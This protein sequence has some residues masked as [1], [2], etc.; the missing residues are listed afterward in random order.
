MNTSSCPACGRPLAPDAPFGL[1][2][3]CLLR[4]GV[5]STAPAAAGASPRFVAPSPDE[6]APLFPQLEI[7]ALIGQGGMGAVYRARQA[8]L[9]RTV[10]L[11]ILPPPTGRDPGFTERFARE[12]RAL[13]RLSHPNIVAVHDVG[14]T[15]G[16]HYLLME[17]VD[18]VTLRHLLTAGKIAPREA[19]AIVPQICDALQYAHDKGI[20][21]RDIKPENILLDKTGA[22]KIADFGLAKIVGL[23]APDF[24]I[25]GARDVMGTL[26]YMA[27]EQVEH[28]LEVDHRADIYSVGVVFYQMLTGELPLGR[29]APPSRKV[30]IDVRLDEVVLRAL[31]KEPALRYQQAS[32]FKTAVE[33]V[34]ASPAAATGATAVDVSR[35]WE[36][37][38]AAQLWGWPLVHIVWGPDPATGKSPPAKGIIAIGGLAI[39]GV[40]IGGT[41]MGGLTLGGLSLGVFAFG[42]TAI[43]AFAIGGLAL[44]LLVGLGGLVFAPV[45]LGLTAVGYLALGNVA[46]G[47][48]AIG[49]NIVDPAARDFFVKWADAIV[50]P[51]ITV[52]FATAAITAIV[53]AV[54]AWRLLRSPLR[55]A[56]GRMRP[57]LWISAAIACIAGD[58][59]LLDFHAAWR[60][61]RLRSN[62]GFVSQL[63][64]LGR[65]AWDNRDMVIMEAWIIDAPSEMKVDATGLDPRRETFPAG[66]QIYRLFAPL[67]LPLGGSFSLTHRVPP[68]G[69][70]ARFQLS[71]T[72]ARTGYDYRITVT[73]QGS[74]QAVRN[75]SGDTRVQPATK[76]EVATSG[77]AEA[78]TPCLF[79]LGS[80]TSGRTQTVAFVLRPW[81]D[82]PRA[83]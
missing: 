73:F 27:P 42:G 5:A 25:T 18:G 16:Y 13:A 56:G 12:A 6:L 57:V 43:G 60:G 14:E 34:A 38:S 21:H 49:P 41:A 32:G 33:T 1:C 72:P 45:A 68:A 74:A 77:R 11:K 67:S 40:A 9:D 82:D 54:M 76:Q 69:P 8:S 50:G 3:D 19:L 59:L 70:P 20:V 80:F 30:H 31:E 7:I 62:I 65:A 48:H 79:E 83:P 75:S 36:Y 64:A 35:P 63:S 66:V 53:A 55:R 58:I 47:V 71:A 22:V 28:P 23:E 24:T 46:V 4:A 81:S 2:A 39:G 17:F 51:A 37:R 44:A 29:F 61:H 78:D 52:V 15:G 10:A 26:H